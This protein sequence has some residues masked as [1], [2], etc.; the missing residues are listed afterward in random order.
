MSEIFTDGHKYTHAHK[1]TQ[2][3]VCSFHVMFTDGLVCNYHVITARTASSSSHLPSLDKQM[4]VAPGLLWKIVLLSSACVEPLQMNYGLWRAG[5]KVVLAS[6][7]C[8]P[9]LILRPRLSPSHLCLSSVPPSPAVSHTFVS[10]DFLALSSFLSAPLYV[11]S[12][13]EDK[14]YATESRPCGVARNLK[15]ICRPKR[16]RESERARVL[17]LFLVGTRGS[18]RPLFLNKSP[19]N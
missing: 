19:I 11:D 14:T 3:P 16:V 9:S 4:L 18:N 12:T 10:S 15:Y 5:S 13:K 6:L 2:V 17:M 7:F 8:F 1:R